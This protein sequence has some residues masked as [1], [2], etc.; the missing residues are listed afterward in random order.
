M[1]KRIG[2]WCTLAVVVTYVVVFIAMLVYAS[3]AHAGKIRADKFDPKTIVNIQRGLPYQQSMCFGYLLEKVDNTPKN[4]RKYM[5]FN[6]TDE[7]IFLN[8]QVEGAKYVCKEESLGEYYP[9]EGWNFQS[10]DNVDW[11]N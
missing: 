9:G 2:F 10:Y 6:I 8:D 7:N 4:E 3:V 5:I 11:S 1:T